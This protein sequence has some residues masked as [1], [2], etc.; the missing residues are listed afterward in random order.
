MHPFLY[1]DGAIHDFKE[2]V[3]Q[4]GAYSLPAVSVYGQPLINNHGQ[5]ALT[6]CQ[7]VPFATFSC[8]TVQLSPC[9]LNP[10]FTRCC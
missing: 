9:H 1:A 2:F 5:I 10:P 6:L 7:Q 8:P 3:P 4:P